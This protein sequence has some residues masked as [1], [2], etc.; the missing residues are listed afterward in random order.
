ME[1]GRALVVASSLVGGAGC[2]MILTAKP[3]LA[4]KELLHAKVVTA[5][6]FRF[7]DKDGR[8]RAVISVLPDGIIGLIFYD[9][10]GIRRA[11]LGVLP[12]GRPILSLHGQEGNSGAILA[13]LPDELPVLSLYGSEGKSGAT[14]GL[15]T[16]GSPE[17]TFYDKDHNPIWKAPK[18]YK[19]Y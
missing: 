10:H 17:L 2:G 9:K 11:L 5:E 18:S 8:L 6:E 12:N 3:A 14:L 13:V 15:L 19:K 7:L 4:E 1:A 16:D